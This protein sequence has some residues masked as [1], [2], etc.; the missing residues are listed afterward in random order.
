MPTMVSRTVKTGGSTGGVI[1]PDLD[2]AVSVQH[3]QH[4]QLHG[5]QQVGQTAPLPLELQVVQHHEDGLAGPDGGLE[6]DRQK[7]GCLRV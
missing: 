6:A 3:G 4:D 1:H 2:G 5:Q 7:A